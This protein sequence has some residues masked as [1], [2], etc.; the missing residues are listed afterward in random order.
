[1]LRAERLDF[2]QQR[3][4]SRIEKI[5]L[6]EDQIFVVILVPQFRPLGE[7]DERQVDDERGEVVDVCVEVRRVSGG[8]LEMLMPDFAGLQPAHRGDEH[9]VQINQAQ[10]PLFNDDVSVLQVAVGDARFAQTRH[11]FQPLVRQMPEHVWPVNHVFQIHVQ[12]R[13]FDPLH[14]QRRE[15]APRDE[16]PVGEIFETRQRGNVLRAQVHVN[17][18]VTFRAVAQVAAKTTHGDGRAPVCGFELEHVGELAG[19]DERHAEPVNGGQQFS[20]VR[21]VEADGGALDGFGE[22]SRARP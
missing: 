6:R 7:R 3:G 17:R 18:L 19:S 12:R 16:Y 13:A 10:L 9:A 22:L 21:L 8:V 1:V 14:D 11:Q 5:L 15:P 2:R 4:R 20:D